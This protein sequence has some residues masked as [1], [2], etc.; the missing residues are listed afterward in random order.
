MCGAI[1]QPYGHEPAAAQIAR[2]WKRDRQR[3]A[4]R[5][6]GIDRIAAL[7]QHI[8]PGGGGQAMRG[9]DH[10]VIGGNRHGRGGKRRL[11]NR[12]QD[13]RARYDRLNPFADCLHYPIIPV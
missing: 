9:N 5:H 13:E 6:G 10:A 7:A 3:I 12:R 2:L 11:R 8:E 1:G 4:D